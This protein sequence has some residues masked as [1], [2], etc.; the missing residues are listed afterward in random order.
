MTELPRQLLGYGVLPLWMAAGLADWWCH[1]RTA[2]ATTS[3]VRESLFHLLLF[4]QMGVGVLAA[5]LLQINALLLALLAALFVLHELT[6][7]VELRFV[8]SRREVRPV[9]QMVHSF[10]ELLPLAGLLLLAVVAATPADAGAAQWGLRWKDQPLPVA[11]VAAAIIAAVLLN[12]LPLLE[13]LQRC[14]RA[15]R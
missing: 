7:W 8:V 1:R 4:A 5:L 10:M 9:E 12:L 3:G 15:R 2:I 6:A 11:Y 14:L 13:E